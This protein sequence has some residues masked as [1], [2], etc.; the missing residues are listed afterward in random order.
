[1]ARHVLVVSAFVLMGVFLSSVFSKP[2]SPSDVAIADVPFV[3][4]TPQE[5]YLTSEAAFS[6]LQD[7]PDILFIDVRDPGE[8]A[9]AGHPE[10]LDAIVPIRVHVDEFDERLGQYKL[11]DNPAFL[12]QMDAMLIRF[13][14][15]KS[16]R[17]IVTCGSG[18]RSAKAARRLAQAGY[19]DVWH[20]IDGYEGEERPG[21]NLQNAW[22][23]AGLPWT[24]TATVPGSRW[25][26]LF[27]EGS[28]T[29]GI[30]AASQDTS[31]TRL[32]D[33]G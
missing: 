5:L 19:T 21:I 13:E 3:K 8:I 33:G 2:E 22:Q 25:D 31:E 16:D 26:L 30:S 23:L 14:K 17:I 18:W 4:R 28:E 27:G 9:V 11:A 32:P 6:V 7:N 12:G 15:T 1:M 10:P 20:I 24:T 29:G